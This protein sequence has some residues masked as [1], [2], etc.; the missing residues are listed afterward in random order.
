MD[1]VK[2][3]RG[4]NVDALGVNL[5]HLR[6]LMGFADDGI[7][8]MFCSYIVVVLESYNDVIIF[9]STYAS[10]KI[11]IKSKNLIFGYLIETI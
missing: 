8:M 4:L 1:G 6:W 9:V 7:P 10:L 11:D 3:Q 5:N 2:N